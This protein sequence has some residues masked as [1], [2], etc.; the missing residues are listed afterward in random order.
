MSL[1]DALWRH[2]R[3]EL[4]ERGRTVALALAHKREKEG[5]VFREVAKT[6]GDEEILVVAETREEEAQKLKAASRQEA[7]AFYGLFGEEM[8]A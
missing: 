8:D 4:R 2:T 5:R 1:I 7:D 3:D 6:T